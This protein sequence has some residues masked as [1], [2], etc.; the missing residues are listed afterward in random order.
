MSS[1]TDSGKA[2]QTKSSDSASRSLLFPA[3]VAIVLPFVLINFG[4]V[5]YFSTIGGSASD[6]PAG[7]IYTLSGLGL[8]IS[9]VLVWWYLSPSQRGAAFPLE[10]LSQAELRWALIFVPLGILA[11]LG[12]EQLGVLLGGE[13]IELTYDITELPTLI[14]VV[15]GAIIVAP[16]VEELI[17]RG[18]LIRALEERGWS[19][20]A[21]GTGSVGVFAVTHVFSLGLTGVFAIAGMAVFPTVLRLRF[22]NITGA[23]LCHFLNN[24]VAYILMPLLLFN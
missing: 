3:V 7:V 4:Y 15:F 11:F 16:L 1:I 13:P 24:V 2:S 19:V 21:I 10:R 23:W 14:G 6:P 20:L 8:L 22:Q 17:Y 9:V 18:I 5:T 12:G